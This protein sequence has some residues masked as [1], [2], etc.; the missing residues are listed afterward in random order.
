MRRLDPALVNR[1]LLDRRACFGTGSGSGF[2]GTQGDVQVSARQWQHEA[3]ACS[4]NPARARGLSALGSGR[5]APAPPLPSDL[6]PS[7]PSDGGGVRLE[8]LSRGTRQ[9][10]GTARAG[11]S[12]PPSVS[13]GKLGPAHEEKSA[14]RPSRAR[15]SAAS[16][17]EH[18]FNICLARMPRWTT[19]CIDPVAPSA[20]RRHQSW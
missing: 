7:S 15:L 10:A 16:A 13:L 3:P 12:V 4:R 19:A 8:A 20:E 1:L 5:E 17:R 18:R 6:P 9:E 14:G 11:G 2:G